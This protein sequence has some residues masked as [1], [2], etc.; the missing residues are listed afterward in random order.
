VTIGELA[1]NDS[2]VINEAPGSVRDCVQAFAGA[3]SEVVDL[4]GSVAIPDAGVPVN[5]DLIF[6]GSILGPGPFS[7]SNAILI[8]LAAN[9]VLDV[10]ASGTLRCG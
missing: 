7:G 3:N 8:A 10:N 4:V 2:V 6:V 5:E 1:F 9:N